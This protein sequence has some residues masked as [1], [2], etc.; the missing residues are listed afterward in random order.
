MKHCAL[1]LA[2]CPAAALWLRLP[3]PPA[4]SWSSPL[5]VM[6]SGSVYDP[7]KNLYTFVVKVSNPERILHLEARVE[8]VEGGKQVIGPLPI[9]MGGWANREF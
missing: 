3:R 9:D 7:G 8:E 2:L 5:T 1:F 4:P 6:L